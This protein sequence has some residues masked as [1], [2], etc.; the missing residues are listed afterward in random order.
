MTAFPSANPGFRFADIVLHDGAANG[1]RRLGD[2]DVPVFDCLQLLEPSSFATWVA[3]VELGAKDQETASA[4]DLLTDLAMER[5]L[6]AEDW[7][8]SIAPICRECSEGRPHD[9]HEHPSP[10]V[11]GQHRVAIAARDSAQVE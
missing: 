8:T 10:E 6:A 4:I 3:E 5:G 11:I 7:S 2:N 1:Y 9:K